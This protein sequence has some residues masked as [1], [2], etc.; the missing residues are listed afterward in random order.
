MYQCLKHTASW[1]EALTRG[2]SVRG[3]L[4]TTIGLLVSFLLAT[5]V[6]AHA[7]TGS[8]RVTVPS[9]NAASLGKFGDV[10]VSLY[11]GVPDIS[12]PLFTAKSRT[13]ELPIGLRYH[14]GGIKVEEIGSWIGIGWTLEAGGSITRTVRGL[15]D[16]SAAG[17]Y[18][19]GQTFYNAANWPAPPDSV[20]RNIKDGVLDGDPDQF[21]FSFAGRSGQFV[22]GPTTTSGSLKEVRTIPYQK[23]K[24]EPTIAGGEILSWLITAEDGTQYTFAA[25]EVTTDQSTL[26]PA[27][28]EAGFNRNG[29]SYTSAWYLTQIRSPGGDVI[30]LYYSAPYLTVHRQGGYQEMNSQITNACVPSSISVTNQY[31]TNPLFVDS[32][33]TAAHTIR[34][35]RSSVLRTDALS[36][37]GSAQ[38]PLLDTIKVTTPAGTLLRKWRLEHDYSTGRLTLTRVYEQD[39]NGTSLPPYVLEYSSP[40]LPSTASYA[41]DHWGFYNSAPNSSL[42]PTMTVGGTTYSGANR[43]PNESAMKAGSLTKITYPTGGYNEFVYEANDYPGWTDGTTTYAGAASSSEQGPQQQSFTIGGTQSV[44]VTVTRSITPD[45]CHEVDQPCPYVE[46]TG[47]GNWVQSGVSTLTLSPGT[48]TLVASDEFYP[49]NSASIQVEWQGQPVMAN[50]KGGGIRIAEVHTA[51]AMGALSI[52]KYRYRLQ[53]DTSKT[54]GIINGEPRYYYQFS[55]GTCSYFSRSSM[56][57]VPLGD[58]PVVGYQEVTIWDGATGEFGKTRHAFRSGADGGSTGWPFFKTT[59]YAWERGQQTELNEYDNLGRSQRRVA[60]SYR[61]RLEDQGGPEPVTTRQFRG[62]SIYTWPGIVDYDIHFFSGEYQ[63]ISA[64]L[65]QD[66]DTTTVFDTTGTSS[67]STTRAFT[68]ANPNHAQLT[69]TSETNSDGTQRITRMRYPADYV[70]GSGNAEAAALT[71]MQGTSHMQSPVIER[72]VIKRSGGI[73]SVVQAELTSFKQFAAGQYLPYQ[74]FALNSASPITDFAP[75]SISGGSFIKDWRHLL[76]ET[77]NAYD[78]QGRITQLTDARGKV[79]NYQYGGNA[80]NAFLTQVAGVHDGSGSTDLVTTLAYDGDGNVQS[81]QDE[82]GSFRYFTYDLFGRLRQIKNSS[83]V[84]TKAYGYTYSRTSPSWSFNTS[85]PNAVIDTTFLQQ[86]PTQQ[87]VVTSQYLDGLGRP[88]QSVTQ[89]GASFV[90]TATQYDVMGRPWRSWKPYARSSSGYDPSFAT[91]ATSYYNSYLGQTQAKPYVETQYR[92]DALSRVDRVIPE[93]VGT[94]PTIFAR[95]SYGIDAT[96]KQ[97][98]LEATDES[99]KKTRTFADLFGNEVKR[100]LGYGSIDSTKTQF[101]PDVLGRRIKV[102]DPRA[103]VT[104]YGLDTRG[105]LRTKTSPDAGT[106]SQKYDAAG[107]ARYSQDANQAAVGQVYFT[108]YDFAGRPL[109]SGLGTAT[110][111]TLNPDTTTPPALETTQSNWVVVRYYDAKPSTAAFPWSAFSTQIAPLTLANVTGRLAAVASKSSGAW[112]VSLFSYDADGR[113]ATRYTYTQDNGGASV[114]TA[115]NTTLSYTRDLR[116]AITQRGLTV[117]SST[118]NHWYDYDG[119]GLLWKVYASP[120]VTKPASADVTYTYRPSGQVQ[121]RQFQGGPL[122]PLQYSIRE[123]LATIGDPASTSYPFSARYSYNANGTISSA[124]FYNAGS[125]AAQKRYKY[126]FP[127]YDALNRLKS[128]DFSS[129][130]GSAWSATLAYDLANIGYDASGNITTLQRY[131]DT[132]TLIDNLTYSYPSSSN[133]LSALADAAGASA[134]NW[135]AESGSFTHDANGNMLAA[136]APYSLSAVTY[137]HRNLPTSLTSNGVTSSYRYDD[138]GARIVKQVGGGNREVYVLD[139]ATTLSVMTLNASG[140]PASWYFNVLAGDR[141]VGREPNGGTRRYYQADLLGTTRSVVQG[142]SVVESY[143][144]DPWGVLMP[145]RTLGTGT[146]EGFTGKERDGETTLDYFGARYYMAAIARWS[147]VDP[148]TDKHP[149][150]SPYNYVLDAPM[151][152]LDPDGAQVSANA[153][154]PVTATRTPFTRGPMR[155][156]MWA[157]A[158][159]RGGAYVADKGAAFVPGV[160]TVQDVTAVAT[161]KD[162]TGEDVG[163]TGRVLALIGA[164]SPLSGGQLHVMLNVGAE[165][166]EGGEKLASRL[167]AGGGLAAHEAAGGHTLLKHVGQTE[168]Q[169][170][171][172]LASERGIS[173]ASTFTSR[174]IAEAAVSNAIDANAT[175]IGAWLGGKADRLVVTQSLGSPIGTSLARGASQAITATSVRIV[176]ERDAALATGYRIVTSYPV[177]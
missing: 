153:A 6:A 116:D 144:Y 23:W 101:T 137:D 8:L 14:A 167:V 88:I 97:D 74:R 9:P 143:D 72:W 75:A 68:Y 2:V 34:F 146:K 119:R 82:G 90:V 133:R 154:G 166:A 155:F 15:V 149:E 161:G 76:Q 145:A 89:N 63:V 92:A 21:F 35:V 55:E 142:A 99:G 19:T 65:Y 125:P 115:V 38:E 171:A 108:N 46:I 11:T 26:S 71:A 118:F 107:N 176:L 31:Q 91:N 139:G 87:S 44:Q 78:A 109:T 102:T 58:G 5:S 159:V 33:K 148:L 121:D 132:G 48:Y 43:E 100:I 94:S 173:A 25:A 41:Q 54:S 174:A 86:T 85:N 111:A 157:G 47:H 103:L 135:D 7:Q 177:P 80:N 168:E 128:A 129:W 52:H 131:R 110:F 175:R 93:F 4:A 59:S 56:S 73:D 17:Y 18:N 147:A 112:Q 140:A 62:M 123:Q 29:E 172:R 20:L 28:S 70:A 141:A 156:G 138:A 12:I 130:N 1:R 113:V 136:P 160:S 165:T 27:R 69:E 122:V 106:V 60:S 158:A 77:A 61:N 114:L 127:S 50:K 152:L 126:D 32:I 10:P 3:S 163:T 51:D 124:E 45:P 64:W 67:Y 105:L 117:G 164:L 39:R 162:F 16:E 120:G 95:R 36:P 13:L 104:S 42:I 170:A 98:L 169:L 81:I 49:G 37:G 151:D 66:A 22:M 24:I 134:E 150:W 57:K 53:S 83:G 96:Q 79:T 30:T 40:T 84:V